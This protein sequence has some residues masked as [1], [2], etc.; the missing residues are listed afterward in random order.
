MTAV[1]AIKEKVKKDK[2]TGKNCNTQKD[3]KRKETFKKN[4]KS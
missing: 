2:K 4:N 3:S 1:H